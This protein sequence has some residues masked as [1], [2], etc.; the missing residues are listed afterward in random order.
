MFTESAATNIPAAN[1]QTFPAYAALLLDASHRICECGSAAAALFGYP[2]QAMIG[3]PVAMLLPDL[4]ALAGMRKGRVLIQLSK[5]RLDGMRADGTPLRVMV[6]LLNDQ[7]GG[8]GQLLLCIRA[9]SPHTEQGERS[10]LAPTSSPAQPGA[11]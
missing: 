10:R 9:L 1:T 3:Q 6:S 11:S 8:S 7:D 4:A 2:V 5:V